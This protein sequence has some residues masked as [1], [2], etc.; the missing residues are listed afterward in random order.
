M[1]LTIAR[2]WISAWRLCVLTSAQLAPPQQCAPHA[3]RLEHTSHTWIQRVAHVWHQL[4]AHLVLTQNLQLTF[5][6]PVRAHAPLV[7]IQQPIACHAL[8][9]I[10]YQRLHIHVWACAQP[11][12]TETHRH[13]SARTAITHA[14]LAPHP[15]PPARLAPTTG[16]TSL[17]LLLPHA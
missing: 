17:T 12:S 6:L 9:R 13:I 16:L 4:H 15:P 5:A 2:A 1:Q 11:A 8:H 7:Q 10:T 3:C 14:Q